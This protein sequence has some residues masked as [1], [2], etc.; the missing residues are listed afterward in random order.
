MA[1]NLSPLAGAGWQFFSDAGLP[2]TGGKLYTYAAGT[3]TPQVTYTSSAGL[4]ANSNPIFLNSAGRL[5]S[6]VWITEGVSY[7]FVLKTSLD[8]TIGTY[9]NIAGINDFAASLASVYTAFASTASNALGDALVGFKQ[10][11]ASGFLANS[12]ARTVNGKL[13]EFINVKDFGA[14]G[15]GSTDD[16]AAIQAAIDYME[17]INGGVVQI[18]QGSFKIT[19]TIQLDGQ[20]GVQ[21]IGQGSDGIHDGGTGAAAATTL[22]WYGSAGETM[23]NV[24]SPSGAS[25]S[26]QMGSSVVDIKFDCRTIAGIGVFLNSVRNVTCSRLFI[27]NPTIAAL[28]TTTLGNTLLGESSDT[29]QCVFDRVSWRCIDSVATQAAHGIWLTSH[30]PIGSNANSSLN[31]FSQCGGQN[32]G[33]AGSGYGLFV[34][35]GDN[36]TFVNLRIFRTGGTTVEAV[37]LVGNTSCDANHFWNLSA[38]GANSIT[39]K[40]TVSGFVANPRRNSFWTTDVGNGTQYPTVDAGVIFGWNSDNNVFTKQMF[41]QVVIADSETQ[42]IANFTNLSNISQYIV[43]NSSSHTVLTDSVGNSWGINI[44]GITGDLRLNRISGSGAVDVGNGSPVK[45]FGKSV[46][47]GTANSGGTGYKVLRVIN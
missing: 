2:L 3:T 41:S 29:Q 12:V 39:I 17:S 36:N 40:G 6:E 31:L 18:P 19:S 38:G 30:S 43:N 34:E 16:T 35:D 22:L 37:R 23:L 27:L 15:D 44:D 26:R 24:S 9:D 21:L 5:A 25:Y 7:K 14:V 11:N 20:M 1:V 42:A 45:I 28:K 46:T 10:S 33:G 47:E 32:W 8:V 4:T 13:Q